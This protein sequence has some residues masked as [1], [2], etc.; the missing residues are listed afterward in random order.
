MSETNLNRIKSTKHD[1][2]CRL[3]WDKNMQ[4]NCYTNH[5]G[6]TDVYGR[7]YWDKPSPTVTTRF[8]SYSNGRYGHPEQDRAIS[9]REGAALQS[10]PDNYVFHSNSQ[11]IIAKMIGNAVPPLL[12]KAVGEVFIQNN[13]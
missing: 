9:L 12:A 2:G 4:P 13:Q 7:M 3:D 8:V 5:A 1:G 10:F 6:H 11:G